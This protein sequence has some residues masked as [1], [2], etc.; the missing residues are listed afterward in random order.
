MVRSGCAS[1]PGCSSL[2]VVETWYVFASAASGKTRAAA[3]AATMAMTLLLAARCLLDMIPLLLPPE[4]RRG[5]TGAVHRDMPTRRFT[6]T[7]SARRTRVQ[8]AGN[9]TDRA[10]AGA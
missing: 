7:A 3:K 2:P 10:A 5:V 4:R 6:A 1:V 9:E 8:A